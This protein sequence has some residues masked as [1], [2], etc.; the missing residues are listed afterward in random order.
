MNCYKLIWDTSHVRGIFNRPTSV[1]NLES[2]LKTILMLWHYC[3]KH[4][5][6]ELVQC[7][8]LLNTHH[9]WREDFASPPHTVQNKPIEGNYNLNW[10]SLLHQ[11]EPDWT[12]ISLNQ[13][14]IRHNGALASLKVINSVL[15]STSFLSIIVHPQTYSDCCDTFI[16]SPNTGYEKMLLSNLKIILRG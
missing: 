3:K 1:L 11:K 8:H 14:Q 16:P 4:R 5:E 7:I 6:L 2:A 12:E 13:Y 10:C 9:C 15:F